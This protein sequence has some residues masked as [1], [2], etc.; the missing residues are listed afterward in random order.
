MLTCCAIL[1]LGLVISLFCF[2][3]IV[4]AKKNSDC[5]ALNY[6]FILLRFYLLLG[7]VSYPKISRLLLRFLCVWEQQSGQSMCCTKIP[8]Q[9][10]VVV[11]GL[12]AE[13][14]AQKKL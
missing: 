12:E 7:A 9:G 2:L 14:Q 6:V 10:S 1:H 3:G 5:W 4:F 8:A 11:E 13:E